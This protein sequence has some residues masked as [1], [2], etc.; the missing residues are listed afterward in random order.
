MVVL[1]VQLI[2]VLHIG[3]TATPVQEA[4][5]IVFTYSVAVVEAVAIVNQNGYI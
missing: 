4:D 5:Y 3:L 2:A 1:G